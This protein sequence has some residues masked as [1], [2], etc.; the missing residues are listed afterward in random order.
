[1]GEHIAL[2]TSSQFLLR[3][4]HEQ[5][6]KQHVSSVLKTLDLL[7]GQLRLPKHCL[8]AQATESCLTTDGPYQHISHMHFSQLYGIRH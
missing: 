3:K 1:M 8:A 5:E 4:E 6:M 7:V 2:S